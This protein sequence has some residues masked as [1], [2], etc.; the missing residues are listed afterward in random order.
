MQSNLRAHANTHTCIHLHTHTGIQMHTMLPWLQPCVKMV[1]DGHALHSDGLDTADADAAAAEQ[2][3]NNTTL[4]HDVSTERSIFGRYSI[5]ES[6]K[7]FALRNCSQEKR[8]YPS[9]GC[10]WRK[11]WQWNVYIHPS[12]FPYFQFNFLRPIK[13]AFDCLDWTT[14]RWCTPKCQWFTLVQ[15]YVTESRCGSATWRWR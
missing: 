8:V 11:L 14:G 13:Y 9:I 12:S 3:H 7:R 15:G 4:S 1:P 5:Y 6:W 2:S 10:F